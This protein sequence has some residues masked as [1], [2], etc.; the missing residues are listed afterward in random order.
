MLADSYIGLPRLVVR[1]AASK[2]PIGH[3]GMVELTITKGAI[4]N[5]DADVCVVFYPGDEL[6]LIFDQL[7]KRDII[8]NHRDELW[9]EYTDHGR[10][11]RACV[12]PSPDGPVIS[13]TI[14]RLTPFEEE[15]FLAI[16]S[17]ISFGK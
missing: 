11:I 10:L 7:D 13:M 5:P 14:Q 3:D 4:E 12:V 9:K 16:K 1:S 6:G 17:R 15:R 2:S 8:I